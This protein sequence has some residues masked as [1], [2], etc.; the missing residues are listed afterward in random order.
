MVW[1]SVTGKDNTK[2]YINRATGETCLQLPHGVDETTVLTA[3]GE[4][5]FNDFSFDTVKAEKTF[6]ENAVTIEG[7]HNGPDNAKY[8]T[9]EDLFTADMIIASVSACE[10]VKKVDGKISRESMKKAWQH[11]LRKRPVRDE[12]SDV[13]LGFVLDQ[14]GKVV[15]NEKPDHDS[16]WKPLSTW[17]SICMVSKREFSDLGDGLS[18]TFQFMKNESVF[19]FSDVVVR[20]RWMDNATSEP[21]R[22]HV[23]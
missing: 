19:F 1:V 20:L 5:A 11:Y 15:L 22:Y 18:L 6:S 13:P 16:M 21:K 14:N 2:Y 10:K 12:L 23:G 17:R 8:P 3:S 9:C 7:H 4:E